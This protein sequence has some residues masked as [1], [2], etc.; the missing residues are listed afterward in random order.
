M[1]MMTPS[2]TEIVVMRLV[3]SDLVHKHRQKKQKQGIQKTEEQRWLRGVERNVQHHQTRRKEL[4][5]NTKAKE[6]RY[7]E[8][9][10]KRAILD[11]VL[12]SF[13]FTFTGRLLL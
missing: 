10:I 1:I 4:S 7:R 6:E 8:L 2:L 3:L 13:T 12:G 5:Y 11:R 9:V